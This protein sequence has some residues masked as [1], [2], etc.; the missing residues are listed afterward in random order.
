MTVSCQRQRA[1]LLGWLKC[2]YPIHH[3]LMVVPACLNSQPDW[4]ICSGPLGPWR[5]HF[6][7]SLL[8]CRLFLFAAPALWLTSRGCPAW[9][10]SELK[11][12]DEQQG[13]V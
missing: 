6:R 3:V 13:A 2:R 11:M 4:R 1:F 10:H 9:V 5:E 12:Q 8:P 7:A